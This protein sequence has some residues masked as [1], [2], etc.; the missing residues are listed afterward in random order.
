MEHILLMLSDWNVEIDKRKWNADEVIGIF[1]E[2]GYTCRI[3]MYTL[4]R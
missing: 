2:M 1:Y 3:P 4:P